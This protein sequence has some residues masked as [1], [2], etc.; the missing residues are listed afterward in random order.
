MFMLNLMLFYV[1][2]VAF[3]VHITGLRNKQQCENDRNLSAPTGI[4]L[5]E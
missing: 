2:N 4:Y 3:V 1:T 5:A